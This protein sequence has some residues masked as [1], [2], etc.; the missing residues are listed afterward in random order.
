MKTPFFRGS[1]SPLSFSLFT[2]NCQRRWSETAA[3]QKDTH[4]DNENHARRWSM[5]WEIKKDKLS[6]RIS[7]AK[8]SGSF[9]KTSCGSIT[10]GSVD[11]LS[12]AIQLLSCRAGQRTLPY[13]NM[14]GMPFIEEPYQDVESGNEQVRHVLSKDCKLLYSPSQKEE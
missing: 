13:H 4:E 8:A 10:D 6:H 12:E 2:Q 1:R 11:G 9:N 5:P 14:V 7:I 3:V